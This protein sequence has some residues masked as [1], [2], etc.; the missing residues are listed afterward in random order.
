VK[1]GK[2]R[3]ESPNFKAKKQGFS[4]LNGLIDGKEVIAEKI[5]DKVLA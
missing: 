2:G 1:E 3:L 5:K 4:K